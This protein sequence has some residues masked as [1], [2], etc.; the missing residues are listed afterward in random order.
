ML[1]PQQNLPLDVIAWAVSQ[2]GV[3]ECIERYEK[4]RS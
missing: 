2:T 1:S 3:E 4:S